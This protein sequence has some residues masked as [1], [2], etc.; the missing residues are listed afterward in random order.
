MQFVLFCKQP[1]SFDILRPLK[2]EIINLGHN[3]LWFVP[4]NIKKKFPWIE[5]EHITSSIKDVYSFKPD[6]IYV[7]GN[8]VPH[9]LRGLKVQVFHGFAGEKKGHFRIRKYFDMYCTPGPYFTERF[10]ELAKKHGDFDVIETGWPKLDGIFT[11]KAD[12][13]SEKK[14]ILKKHNVNK[15][16]LYAPTFSP[17]LTSAKDLLG[18]FYR[19]KS[20]PDYLLLIK[21]HDLMDGKFINLYK[22]LAYENENILFL[23]ERNILKY[24]LLADLMISDTSSAVYEFLLLNKPVISFNTKSKHIRWNNIKNPEHLISTINNIFINDTYSG[25]REWFINN[26]HPYYDGKS[27]QRIVNETLNYIE[28]NPVPEKRNIPF[29]RKRKMIRE[30]GR[31]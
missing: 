13:I 9:Y 20:N 28:N 18:Q 23:D 14:I 29:L 6:I 1:Y 12:I 24:I 31:I 8:E 2:D 11:K 5:D 17:S 16:I 21:F 3:Y 4:E 26:Y 22:K 25:Q 30:F 27:S 10:K 7:P 19:F 15:I